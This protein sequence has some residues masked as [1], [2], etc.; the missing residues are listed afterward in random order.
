MNKKKTLEDLEE[1]KMKK[2]CK[3]YTDRYCSYKGSCKNCFYNK[4]KK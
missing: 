4:N 2:S 1:E 3:H